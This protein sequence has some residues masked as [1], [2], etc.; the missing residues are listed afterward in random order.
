MRTL[1]A[2]CVTQW[3]QWL[4]AHHDS[5]PEVWLVFRKQSSAPAR[6]LIVPGTAAIGAAGLVPSVRAAR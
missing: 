4:A 3:R 6:R 2:T 5:A 1:R